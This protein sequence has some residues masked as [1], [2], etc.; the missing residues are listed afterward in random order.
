MDDIKDLKIDDEIN[1]MD[2]V[3]NPGN[4]PVEFCSA[5]IDKIK[6]ISGA[7]YDYR[8]HIEYRILKE[9]KED[10]ATKLKFINSEGKEKVLTKNAGKKECKLKPA[11]IEKRIKDKGFSVNQLGSYEF[12]LTS[13]FKCKE[14][15]KQGGDIQKL[16]DS[17]YVQGP[18]TLKVEK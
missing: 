6:N 18:D 4:Y 15:R 9:M 10:N 7:L 2:V 17:L 12:K 14:I 5:V 1:I 11:E 13:W 16:I 8:K 3:K